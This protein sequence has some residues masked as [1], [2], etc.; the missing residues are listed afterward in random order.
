[1]TDQILKKLDQFKAFYAPLPES[2]E[3]DTSVTDKIGELQ[4]EFNICKSIG[5]A[6]KEA[7]FRLY[8]TCNE[9]IQSLK[10]QQQMSPLK[11]VTK[12]VQ[13]SKADSDDLVD[14]LQF[15]SLSLDFMFATSMHL[16]EKLQTVDATLD[17]CSQSMNYMEDIDINFPTISIIDP[18]I[19]NTN[20]SVETI[21][22]SP[23]ESQLSKMDISPPTPPASPSN[24]K[25]SIKSGEKLSSAKRAPK[26]RSKQHS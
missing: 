18:S 3:I 23:T 6:Q 26:D 20:F 16:A 13:D 15:I 17:R 9:Q 19:E 14:K 24:L 21:D 1:M 22:S 7:T 11:L 4:D 25:K 8:S 10:T 2:L 12:V 5:L